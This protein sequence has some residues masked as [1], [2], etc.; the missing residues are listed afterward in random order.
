MDDA[1]VFLAS[2]KRTD[3]RKSVEERIGDVYWESAVSV[4]VTSL[5]NILA[6]SS[7]IFAPYRMIRCFCIYAS[8]AVIFCYVYQ[9]TFVGACMAVCGYVEKQNRHSLYF[10]RLEEPNKFPAWITGV[11]SV[12]KSENT[13]DISMWTQL[14][15]LLSLRRI[16]ILVLMTYAFHV[17]V[18][19][20]GMTQTDVIGDVSQSCAFDSY[21][22]SYY[23]NDYQHFSRFKHRVQI[24]IDQEINYAD[25]KI[26][27]RI[28]KIFK[29]MRE[30]NLIE[31]SL[32]QSWLRSYLEF[33]NDERMSLVVNTYNVSDSY[34]FILL[35]R[36]IFLQHPAAENFRND[37]K[38]D[39]NYTSILGSRFFCQT[40]TIKNEEAEI[41]VIQKMRVVTDQLPFTAFP[42][43]YFSFWVDD[44]DL[45][46][47]FTAQMLGS[48][49]L[50]VVVVFFVFMPDTVVTLSIVFSII[51]IEVS[52]L[53]YMALWNVELAQVSVIVLVMCAGFSVDYSVHLCYAYRQSRSLRNSIESV[54][55]AIFQGSVT[56]LISL[57]P[58]AYPLAYVF[59]ALF[60][61]VFLVVL[62]SV[63]NA[64]IIL[65]VLLTLFDDVKQRNCCSSDEAIINNND[66]NETNEQINLSFYSLETASVR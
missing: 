3:P 62:F 19:F 38:F 14:G 42:Y 52:V 57:L 61:V 44:A 35:L 54:G 1:F 2:W 37:I 66:S 4:T 23:V 63:L 17:S 29:T 9:L 56:T 46:V 45:R 15:N 24:V 31:D 47:K 21:L 7:G 33:L 20:W 5:T 6:F 25:V 13:K 26:Q 8:T 51:S 60:K 16:Q 55:H 22:M 48:V 58:L 34:D 49:V 36:R 32:T 50:V 59:V 43:V 18:G 53:G 40:N 12:W 11:F 27:K 30:E 39:A 41:D 65:P 28:E 64:L 10:I